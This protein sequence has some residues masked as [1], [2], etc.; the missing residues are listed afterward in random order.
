MRSS[1]ENATEAI[2]FHTGLIYRLK[3]IARNLFGCVICFIAC[4]QAH[5]G[6]FY[7]VFI[8]SVRF[9]GGC[10]GGDGKPTRAVAEFI[11]GQFFRKHI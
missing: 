5:I 9:N 8:L 1:D 3:S 7:S 4:Y 2:R 11:H 10:L 6:F